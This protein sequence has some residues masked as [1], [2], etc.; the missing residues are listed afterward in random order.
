MKRFGEAVTC[1]VFAAPFSR[2]SIFLNYPRS[3]LSS[4]FVNLKLLRFYLE[5]PGDEPGFIPSPWDMSSQDSSIISK[6]ALM[7][8]SDTGDF[9]RWARSWL[10][11]VTAPLPVTRCVGKYPFFD[12]RLS[13]GYRRRCCIK[14]RIAGNLIK[15]PNTICNPFV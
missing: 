14:K 4:H 3:Q 10:R 6:I 11:I 15:L 7:S 13:V 5:K 8:A 1:S 12:T 9:L 2:A